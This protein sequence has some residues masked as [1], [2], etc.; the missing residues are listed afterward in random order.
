MHGKTAIDALT[1]PYRTKQEGQHK[2]GNYAFKHSMLRKVCQEMLTN[3]QRTVLHGMIAIELEKRMEDDLTNA[4]AI[5]RHFE[6]A[7]S[8]LHGRVSCYRQFYHQE[9]EN[10][11]IDLI[12]RTSPIRPSICTSR[13]LF[14]TK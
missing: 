10:L 1:H 7:D 12:L 6:C 13:L 14:I 9:R 5:A 2:E 4:G 11:K 3:S 8:L